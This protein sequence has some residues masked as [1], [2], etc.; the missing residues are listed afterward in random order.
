M[1][2]ISLNSSYLPSLLEKCLLKFLYSLVAGGLGGERG[3][4][5]IGHT[6]SYSTPSSQL[7]SLYH[8]WRERERDI[9]DKT[10]SSQFSTQTEYFKLNTE[11]ISSEKFR[12]SKDSPQCFDPMCKALILSSWHQKKSMNQK[13][14]WHL[15]YDWEDKHLKH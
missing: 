12:N 2:S 14:L 8:I 9:L 1:I 15:F 5:Q 6:A 4:G 11:N 10:E 7:F 13:T 3:A